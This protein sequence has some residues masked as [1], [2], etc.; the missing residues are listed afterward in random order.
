MTY[1]LLIDYNVESFVTFEVV[2]V[3]AVSS[4]RVTRIEYE[5]V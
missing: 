5:P 3:T 1:H 4:I 2:V